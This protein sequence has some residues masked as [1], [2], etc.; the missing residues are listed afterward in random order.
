MHLLE[1]DD[2]DPATRCCSRYALSARSAH[3]TVVALSSVNTDRPAAT[4][5]AACAPDTMLADGSA[6]AGE[7]NTAQAAMLAHALTMAL[8]AQGVLPTVRAGQGRRRFLLHHICLC[9]I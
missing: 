6:T 9:L 2:L 1:V 3:G 7:A 8:T 5:D 4:L